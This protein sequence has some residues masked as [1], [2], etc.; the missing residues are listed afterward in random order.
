LFLT[1]YFVHF[2]IHGYAPSCAFEVIVIYLFYDREL[3]KSSDLAVGEKPKTESRRNY[4]HCS[5]TNKR[6]TLDHSSHL[7]YFFLGCLEEE[8]YYTVIK[9]WNRM[10]YLFLSVGIKLDTSGF[11]TVIYSAHQP[12]SYALPGGR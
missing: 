1:F 12:I 4:C 11:T 9:S 7:F 2:I 6:S 3:L 5:L 8:K 10:I